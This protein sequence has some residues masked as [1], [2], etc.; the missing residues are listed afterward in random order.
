MML[1]GNRGANSHVAHIKHAEAVGRQI[2]YLTHMARAG[3]HERS[4]DH[5]SSHAP[6]KQVT[7]LVCGR[8]LQVH[9]YT[10][11]KLTASGKGSQVR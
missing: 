11:G 8:E 6:S 4:E 2:E 5:C 3:M 1:Q 9:W 7:R 10:A